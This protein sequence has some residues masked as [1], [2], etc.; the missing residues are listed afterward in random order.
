MNNEEMSKD[1]MIASIKHQL[2]T[3]RGEILERFDE[4]DS[5]ICLW[6]RNS[7]WDGNSY[8]FKGDDYTVYE[9]TDD[10]ADLL[11]NSSDGSKFVSTIQ[12]AI[13]DTKSW[14]NDPQEW[15]EECI[16]AYIDANGILEKP[17]PILEGK[18][19]YDDVEDDIDINNE[20]A[21]MGEYEM[22]RQSVE[23]DGKG[24]VGNEYVVNFNEWRI[25]VWDGS[26]VL[27]VIK[28]LRENGY[29]EAAYDG[30]TGMKADAETCCSYMHGYDKHF[31]NKEDN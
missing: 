24:L 4:N 31:L 14:Y 18:T 9:D 20:M 11:L 5:I 1:E 30:Y 7:M 13:D 27:S 29:S 8:W 28:D 23:M 17:A 19:S 25:T 10:I 2:G 6:V 16:K 3:G 12:E 26:L 21:F 15:R 22:M